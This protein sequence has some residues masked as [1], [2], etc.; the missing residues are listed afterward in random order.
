MRKRLQ[1]ILL[2]VTF[3]GFIISAMAQ[4]QFASR[5]TV[6]YVT[7]ENGLLNDHIDYL[8]KDSQG[9]LWIATAGGGLS[10]YDGYDFIHFNIN[11]SP[12]NLRSNF[13]I[14]V[15]EDNHQR[16]WIV[17]REGVNIINLKTLQL[18]TPLSPIES[19]RHLLQEPALNVINDS[20]GN[21]WL[22][23]NNEVH[24]ISFN[25]YGDVTGIATL[26]DIPLNS[27][28]FPMSDID[29]DG[30]I[31]IGYGNAVR[32][33][34]TNSKGALEAIPVSP[35]LQF[36]AQT[37]FHSFCLKENEVWIGTHV[38]LLRYNRNEEVVKRY[39]HSRDDERS[40]S[41]NHITD[42]VVTKD[43]QLIVS[44]LQGISIYN[45]LTDDFDRISHTSR[46][47]G[48][49]LIS[50]FVNCMLVDND[51]IW[52]GCETGGIN[53]MSP[54]RLSLRNYV[55]D[56]DNPY[57]L[58]ENLVN[59]ICEDN[60]G[61][62]WV[63]T[64]EGG[65]NKKEKDT[66][67]F[68]HYT[69]DTPLT[70]S[71]NTIS[72]LI[73]DNR[74]RLWVGT[75]GWGI[76]VIDLSTPQYKV[77][78][79]INSYEYPDVPLGFIGSLCYDSINNGVWIG[80]SPG[81]YFYDFNTD[82]VITPIDPGVTNKTFSS[83]GAMI[84]AN[85]SL[86]MGSV[87]GIFVIDL[88]SRHD[89]TFAYRQLKYKLDD[90]ESGIT[91]RITCFYKGPDDTM[92]IGSNGNGFYKC[93]MTTGGR[94]RFVNYTTAHGLINNNV[95]GIVEDNNGQL[96]ISTNYGLSCFDPAGGNFTNYTT[97]DGLPNNQFY[98]NA[99]AKSSDGKVW[100]GGIGGLSS[101]EGR[102]HTHKPQAPRVTFTRLQVRNEEVYAGN[103]GMTV[104]I[105]M[106]TD[107]S[108]HEKDNSFSLEFSS[109]NYESY[110]TGVYS[111]R[112]LGFEEEWI[113]VPAS[114]RFAGYTNIPPGKYTF[115][116]RYTAEGSA[117][118]SGVTSLHI[119]IR[120][121]FYKT[122]WFII[123]MVLT[124]GCS[125]VYFYMRR[126][127][128]LQK[129]K[130]LLHRMVDERTQ[131]LQEQNEK[132]NKQK[133]QLIEMSK[134]VQELT[135]DKLSFFTNITHEFRTPITLIIGPIERALK[136]SENPQVIEQLRFVE[137][138]SKYLL[139][140]VN[141]LMD[142]RKVESGKM[143]ITRVNGD[144]RA[145][146]DALIVPFEVFAADRSITVRVYYRLRDPL[147]L[148]D[149]DAMQKVITNLLSNAVKFTPDGGVVSVYIA[150]L[151]NHEG[152]EQLYICVKD[153]GTGIPEEDLP[154]IFNR[155]YQSKNQAQYPVYGQSSTG[156]GLYLS[157]RIIKL[158]GGTLTAHNNRKTG[159]TFR[160]MQPI[161]RDDKQPV[162]PGFNAMEALPEDINPL[163]SHFKPGRLAVLVVE[164]NRDMRAYIRSILEGQYNIFEAEHGAEALTLLAANQVDFIISDL[165]MPVMDGIELS[166]RVKQN[167]SVSHI[168]FLMLTA[169]TSQESRIESYKTGV[170]EYLLKPFS[171]ELLLT[172]IS[173][174]LENRKRYQQRFA[175][176]MEVSE[177]Q[178]DEESSDKKFIDKVMEVIRA[179][180]KNS[181]YETAD[182]IE[183]MGI[184]KSLLN[185][186]MQHLTGQS[187]GQFIRNYRLNVAYELI[188]K[189]RE[190]HNMNISEIAYEV[191]FNDPKYFTRCFT[192]RYQTSPSS[193]LG[194]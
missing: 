183:A 20:Q 158:H 16:L 118:D 69:T 91:E 47:A 126:L 65:L 61:N 138:N 24:K 178:I 172:R 131:E 176:H 102:N 113:D 53:K 188:E 149:H 7:M 3:H 180:Y 135:L 84:D 92:W 68:T 127:Y 175:M 44:T 142:F 187:I 89:N 106:A 80:A 66:D 108:L 81:I 160:I 185:K 109:L 62:L 17:S 41:Q 162:Y 165:M 55:N 71:H 82:E 34:H 23:G 38:G 144:F 48:S 14:T 32:K 39:N 137:R 99:F 110:S 145:F 186:K 171:E 101:V 15:C 115:Q 77:V 147:I 94:Y 30:Q 49:T 193:L 155:F 128:M 72:T 170:D 11:T 19:F 63:G 2:C 161:L 95:R 86:W 124:V 22:C 28:I 194:N 36:T 6:S 103:K 114:R 139:S 179:N 75:W 5:Y 8:Y 42:I 93:T 156:I 173:N 166:R 146:M 140:L 159:S 177:L 76:T 29:S 98:W 70:L 88:Y 181:N 51:I 74:D 112:L 192:K 79:Y 143:E 189:N 27:L 136:L 167:F 57:S 12:V 100:L 46:G 40:V 153:T 151:T 152:K 129:Q 60:A 174:I 25:E 90:P 26:P 21:I 190:T 52:I 182:F 134:K 164:D 96:W 117:E 107:L 169:K 9:F 111:Y 121:Y 119:T 148:F 73:M 132:V 4:E 116:V 157:A 87:D 56:K 54:R 130:Q 150:S 43:R 133:T 141:Q 33:V 78:K 105:C 35:A 1:L 120:P 67:R 18:T 104:D 45:P 50:N 163:P 59:A 10:R 31:W 64:V 122:W 184:S 168:P 191:G 125:V 37:N 85:G 83:L 154:K 97:E 58:S 123:L 13:I